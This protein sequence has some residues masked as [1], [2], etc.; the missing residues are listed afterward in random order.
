MEAKNAQVSF[1]TNADLLAKAKTIFSRNNVEL[2][3]A[4]NEFL[5]KTVEED[6]LPFAV[7]DAASEK[8]FSELKAEMDTAYQHYVNGEI[9]P[10]SE[11]EKKW[12]I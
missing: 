5:T 7:Y 8:V 1:R 2:S 4:L 9:V 3:R 10:A 12:G 6:A 11:V